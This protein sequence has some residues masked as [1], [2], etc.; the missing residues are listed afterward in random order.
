MLQKLIMF[1][2]DSWSSALVVT[3]HIDLKG[4]A[5]GGGAAAAPTES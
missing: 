3:S 2:Q 4:G 5:A 1:L